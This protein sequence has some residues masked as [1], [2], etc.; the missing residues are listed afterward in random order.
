MRVSLFITCF[1]D[2]L[3]P[4]TG[5]A[6]VRLLERLGH[7]VEFPLEQTCCGQMHYNTGYQREAIP[8]VKRFVEVF[9]QAEVV[10]S[11]SASCVGMVREL[12]PHAAELAGDGDLA[13]A[14]AALAPRVFELSEFLVHKLGVEDVGAYYPHRV[15]YHPT[16]HSL[17]MLRVGDAPLRLLRAVRGMDLV[18][19]PRADECCGFGGTFAVKNADTSMAMLGDKLRCILD[20]RAEVC[21]AAD[22]SCLMHIGG[23]LHRQRAGVG[24]V[25][26]AEILAST[27]SDQSVSQSLPLPQESP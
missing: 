21:A 2:T 23:A 11:P 4:Q 17:R 25:H 15:T 3:F 8:L 27:E 1:N 14:V 24:T 16:C 19:L 13:A 10:V 26:L 7:T 5:R 6:V 9:G 18:V 22:N 12:Y 20:T